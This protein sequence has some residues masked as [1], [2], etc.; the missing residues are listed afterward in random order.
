MKEM[1]YESERA[2]DW[3]TRLGSESICIS[4]GNLQLNSLL[5]NGL[6]PCAIT[7]VV[8]DCATGKTQVRYWVNFSDS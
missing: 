5:Y 3:F 7:E 6:H 4:T 2:L 1:K 8:G